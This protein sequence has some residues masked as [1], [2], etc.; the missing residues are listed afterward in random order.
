[1][2]LGGEKL[3]YLGEGNANLVVAIR[4]KGLVIRSALNTRHI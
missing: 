3:T 1:M 2:S 4:D